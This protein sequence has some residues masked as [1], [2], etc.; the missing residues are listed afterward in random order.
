[1]YARVSRQPVIRSESERFIA[2]QRGDQ[3]PVE[4][5][6]LAGVGVVDLVEKELIVFLGV[7]DYPA[8][9]SL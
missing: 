6:L 1:M 4:H 5:L 9:M 8:M 3:G 2:T 7:V